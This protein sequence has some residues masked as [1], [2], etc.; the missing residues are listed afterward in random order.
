MPVRGP[1]VRAGSTRS[2][3]RSVASPTG[4]LPARA[5]RR[6][7][8]VRPGNPSGG[9]RR[10]SRGTPRLIARTQVGTALPSGWNRCHAERQVPPDQ[11]R[12]PAVPPALPAGGPTPALP[13][14]RPHHHVRTPSPHRATGIARRYRGQ[15][16]Q[17]QGAAGVDTSPGRGS[18]RAD[19]PA[20]RRTSPA[21]PG[22][23]RRAMSQ[24]S[25]RPCPALDAHPCG[26]TR[27]DVVTRKQ[28][29]RQG[30]LACD[31]PVSRRPGQSGCWPPPAASA[32]GA[33]RG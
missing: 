25:A 7:R 1:S 32:R 18:S 2:I 24:V 15:A 3:S 22:S 23:S 19:C 11:G 17:S 12:S 16:P 26:C 28:R 9:R 14:S 20:G 6:G 10:W 29:S 4:C 21:A 30:A 27:Q 5:P 13:S 8:P 33:P 31:R